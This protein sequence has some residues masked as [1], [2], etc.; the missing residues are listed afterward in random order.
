MNTVLIIHV[1][2]LDMLDQSAHRSNDTC[3]NF[4]M[5]DQSEHSS[6]KACSQF[7]HVRSKCTQ[8]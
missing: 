5:L 7:G 8:V 6:H 1:L 3:L 2:N 4:D